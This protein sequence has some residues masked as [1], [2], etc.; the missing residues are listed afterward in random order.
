MEPAWKFTIA[1]RLFFE[2]NERGHLRMRPLLSALGLA[3]AL[4][5]AIVSF[6]ILTGFQRIYKE[7]I[8]KFNAHIVVI[9]G[10]DSLEEIE[11]VVRHMGAAAATRFIYQEGM[12]VNPDGI[13]LVVL[14]GVESAT[15][16]LVYGLMIR[17]LSGRLL[18]DKQA[19]QLLGQSSGPDTPIFV[20][21]QILERLQGSRDPSWY[22][23]ILP[24]QSASD[25]GFRDWTRVFRIVG[26]FES[27]LHKFDDQFVL[28]SLKALEQLL[29]GQSA[30]GL[31]IRL[32]DA[33]ETQKFA[34]ALSKGLDPSTQIITWQEL[35]GPLFN[36]LR[37]EKITFG[38]ILGLIIVIASFSVI[39]LLIIFMIRRQDEM[40]LMMALGCTP[41][42]L[43]GLIHLQALFT[44]GGGICLGSL[45]AWGILQAIRTWG[46]MSL[47]PQIYFVGA[48]PFEWPWVPWCFLISLIILLCYALAQLG[49]RYFLSMQGLTK[50]FR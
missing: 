45:M 49:A 20:G 43:R 41:R 21:W 19:G 48:V 27:G 46:V 25:T 23:I 7:G 33:L 34:V 13:K 39:G 8:L 38:I 2:R 9:P 16:S 10:R 36:A 5:T 40:A 17:D 29:P 44:A 22:K 24:G 35:N 1:W 42:N 26:S 6:S 18:D 50:K 14:K 3:F 30:T 32:K 11:T 47:D 12:G 37:M 31:E 4:M 28:V 15:M